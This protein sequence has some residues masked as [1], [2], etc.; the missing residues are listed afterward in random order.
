MSMMNR[1]ALTLIAGLGSLLL[2][3]CSGVGDGNSLKSLA[4]ASSTDTT[5]TYDSLKAG[6]VS[7]V[8]SYQCISNNLTLYG[9]F[10]KN[11]S[12]GSFTDRATWT[13]ADPNIVKVSN[14]DIPVPGVDGSFYVRGTLIPVGPGSTT[15]TANYLDLSTST[16]VNVAAPTEITMEPHDPRL[17]V[18]TVQGFRITAKLDG[19]LQDVTAATI[20][21]V[22]FSPVDDTVAKA[23][24]SGGVPFVTALAVAGPLTLN[25]TLP[26]C[27]RVLS[28]TVRVAAIPDGG[29]LLQHEAGFN[30]ELVVASN[31]ALKAMVDFGDGPEQDVTTQSTYAVDT[32]DTS[33]TTRISSSSNFVTALLAGSEATVAAKCCQRDLN[34]DGDFLDAGEASTATSNAIG[35][36]PVAGT[37]T[38]FAVSPDN[39]SGEQYTNQQ[40]TVTG[41]FDG[42]ARTQPI[43][44]FVTWSVTDPSTA[45]ATTAATTSPLFAIAAGTF[46]L[47]AGLGVS[48][49]P[50]TG[51][52]LTEAKPLT[53]TATL[54]SALQPSTALA[55]VVTTF[56]LT[57]LAAPAP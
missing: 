28:T 37:L 9:V 51:A 26:I 5:V 33:A 42:G 18:N 34:A 21:T 40:F 20:P 39:G 4:I 46:S 1:R 43:T 53:V 22:A 24:L 57:P 45:T 49:L 30:G 48:T 3:A 36:T 25:V 44:R 29:L 54:N 35:I 50:P 15:V 13:S 23:E 27:S 7:D 10:T 12:V 47:N 55:P 14:G 6:S 38:A 32:T 11:S 17:A 2:G 31:E 19:I 56:T 41:T 52:K 8:T 16:T